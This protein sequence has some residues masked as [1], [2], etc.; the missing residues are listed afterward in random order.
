MLRLA[1][2]LIGSARLDERQHHPIARPSININDIIP[3]ITIALLIDMAR[4]RDEE[5]GDCEEVGKTYEANSTTNI[6]IIQGT[7][8]L[9]INGTERLI[10]R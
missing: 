1:T 9:Y 4:S 2:W 7:C 5:G 3:Q 8:V 6:H 10:V